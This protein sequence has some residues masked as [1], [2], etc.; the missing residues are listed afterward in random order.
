MSNKFLLLWKKEKQKY[1][2]ERDLKLV[3]KNLLTFQTSDDL[4][5]IMHMILLLL[6]LIA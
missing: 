2:L 3:L 5:F 6:V 1:S 4:K